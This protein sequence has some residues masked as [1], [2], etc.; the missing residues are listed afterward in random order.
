[1]SLEEATVVS[2]MCEIAALV[3]VLKRL[4]GIIETGHR[5][6]RGTTH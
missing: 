4:G 6:A 3:D 5:V 2:S 1:M